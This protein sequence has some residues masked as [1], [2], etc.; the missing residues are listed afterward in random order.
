M[1]FMTKSVRSYFMILKASEA[2]GS[3]EDESRT[4][5]VCKRFIM[6]KGEQGPLMVR[7]CA[8]SQRERLLM[9]VWEGAGGC[10]YHVAGAVT[11][12][13]LCHQLLCPL[14]ISETGQAFSRGRN[15]SSKH[16]YSLPQVIAVA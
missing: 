5:F 3:Q 8:K 11:N 1:I 15:F 2:E 9:C 14:H 12:S 7:F 4:E 16:Q 13:C 6:E 10:C